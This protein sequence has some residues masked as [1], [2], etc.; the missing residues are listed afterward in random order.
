MVLLPGSEYVAERHLL[1][2]ILQIMTNIA[3]ALMP[4]DY[5][6]ATYATIC[7]RVV[8]NLINLLLRPEQ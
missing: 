4:K 6:H 3:V 7:S 8:G 1:N 2:G 5:G